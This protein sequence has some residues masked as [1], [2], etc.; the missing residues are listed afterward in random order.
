MTACMDSHRFNKKKKWTNRNSIF[1][2]QVRQRVWKMSYCGV[3]LT[4]AIKTEKAQAF[5]WSLNQSVP[6]SQQTNMKFG[7]G[8]MHAFKKAMGLAVTNSMIRKRMVTKKV[9][10]ELCLGC[11]SWLRGT[12]TTTFSMPMS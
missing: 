7:M 11:V 10:G 4:E 5:Q 8:F 9:H 1:D 2:E 3:F 12:G 6:T